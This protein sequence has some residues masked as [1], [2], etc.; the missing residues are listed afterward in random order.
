MGDLWQVVYG[1][2]DS[3]LIH[4]GLEDLAEAKAIAMKVIREVYNFIHFKGSLGNGIFRGRDNEVGLLV[5]YITSWST[6]AGQ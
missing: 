4:Y 1:D 5:R 2:T 6:S 3:I